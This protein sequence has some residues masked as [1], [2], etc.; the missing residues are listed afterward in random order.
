MGEHALYRNARQGDANG[1]VTARNRATIE[2]ELRT[3]RSP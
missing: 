1:E 3:R 2:E